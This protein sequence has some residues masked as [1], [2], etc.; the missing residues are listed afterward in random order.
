MP[1]TILDFELIIK[2]I[3]AVDDPRNLYEISAMGRF[4]E[5]IEC[6]KI[7]TTGGCYRKRYHRIN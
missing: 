5:Q 3:F 1:G 2:D 4:L 6:K 7:T